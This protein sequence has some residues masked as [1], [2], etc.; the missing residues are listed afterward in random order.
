MKKKEFIRPTHIPN[1]VIVSTPFYQGGESERA[2][3]RAYF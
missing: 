2:K 3:T 1:T